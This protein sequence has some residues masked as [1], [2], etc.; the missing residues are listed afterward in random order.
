MT[1]ERQ[2]IRIIAKKTV[3]VAPGKYKVIKTETKLATQPNALEWAREKEKQGYY[4]YNQIF[5]R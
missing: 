3:R 4:V 2:H 5:Y 1:W